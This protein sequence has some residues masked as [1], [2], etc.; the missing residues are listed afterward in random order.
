MEIPESDVLGTP[1]KAHVDCANKAAC[2]EGICAHQCQEPNDWQCGNGKLCF[3]WQCLDPSDIPDSG[4]D[5]PD[6]SSGKDLGGS[7]Q[8][9]VSNMDCGGDGACIDG[10]CSIE[11]KSDSDCGDPA[12]WDCK[13][14]QCFSI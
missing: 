12:D 3:K 2:I 11:C 9:C 5:T 10:I 6:A 14:F 8:S 1:C 4:P 7:G 13:Q